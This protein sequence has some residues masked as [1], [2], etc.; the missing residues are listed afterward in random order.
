MDFE[1]TYLKEKGYFLIKTTGDTSPDEVEKILMQ[2]FESRDWSDG[3]RILYDGRLEGHRHLLSGE[4]QRM[5]QQ[6]L[7]FNG[8]LANSKI[9]LVMSNDFSFGMARMWEAYTGL[10]AS[11]ETCVFRSIDE[12]SAWIEKGL[13]TG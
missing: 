9:A 1:I 11:F 6:V 2:T 3:A 8:K 10:A 12:A 7:Q 13:G 5:S 4:V